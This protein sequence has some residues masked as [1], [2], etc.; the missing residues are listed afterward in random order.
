MSDSTQRGR[1]AKRVRTKPAKPYRDFPLT[2]NG[3]GQW[4]KKIR[5]KVWYFGPWA[6]PNAAVSRYLKVKDDL[7]AGR[8]PR[9]YGD[10]RLTLH[11]LCN[12]FQ[13]YTRSQFELRPLR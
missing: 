2:A 4:S 3:N 5:G 6:D 1:S 10:T 13:A 12:K 9:P 7:M 11:L 8:T